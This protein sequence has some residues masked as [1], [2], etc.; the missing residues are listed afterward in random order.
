M[1]NTTK[2]GHK[3]FS[4]TNQNVMNTF[5]GLIIKYENLMEDPVQSFAEVISH[6]IQSG[7]E[8]DVDYDLIDIYINEHKEKFQ[9]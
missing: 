4:W 9:D 3:C 7:M 1:E 6:L 5:R 2:V 8:I